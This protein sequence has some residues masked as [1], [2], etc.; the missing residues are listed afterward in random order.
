MSEE[1][2]NPVY[3]T[4]I[5]FTVK[6]GTEH[7]R[8]PSTIDDN[9]K[10]PTNIATIETNDFDAYYYFPSGELIYTRDTGR[11][12]IGNNTYPA[13]KAGSISESGISN[14]ITPGGVLA[15]NKYLG[16]FSDLAF[17]NKHFKFSEYNSNTDAY[18]GD[19]R[20]DANSSILY[21]YDTNVVAPKLTTTALSNIHN[22]S[23]ISG[24]LNGLK[25]GTSSKKEDN[26]K[27]IPFFNFIPDGRT[28]D[29]DNNSEVN[30][31]YTVTGDEN[32]TSEDSTSE[33]VSYKFKILKVVNIESEPVH[34]WFDHSKNHNTKD[35]KVTTDFFVDTKDN[36]KLK[37]RLNETILKDVYQRTAVKE[38]EKHRVVITDATGDL[39]IYSYISKL[40]LDKL[41]GL[42][43]Y[44]RY[45]LNNNDSMS[46]IALQHHIGQPFYMG[47][48]TTKINGGKYN[49]ET[50]RT[51]YIKGN[52]I[53]RDKNMYSKWNTAYSSLWSNIGAPEWIDGTNRGSIWN[54]IGNSTNYVGD[55]E[56]DGKNSAANQ[57]PTSGLAHFDHNINSSGKAS[58]NVIDIWYNIGDPLTYANIWK[59]EKGKRTNTKQIRGN[60]VPTTASGYS[61][62][63]RYQSLWESIGERKKSAT[64]AGHYNLW[65]HIGDKTTYT[66][67]LQTI[68][69]PSSPSSNPIPSIGTK[70]DSLSTLKTTVWGG[71][72]NLR[73][74]INALY[75]GL[76]NACTYIKGYVDN[77]ADSLRKYIDS[78]IA[79]LKS[80]LNSVSYHGSP[81]YHKYVDLTAL[82]KDNAPR[83]TG[84]YVTEYD[85]WL[86]IETP[87]NS[88]GSEL[89]VRAVGHADFVSISYITSNY[90]DGSQEGPYL[91]PFMKGDTIKIV[92]RGSWS[93]EGAGTNS[94]IFRYYGKR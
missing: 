44:R 42:A 73:S 9:K 45:D 62:G 41:N 27:F 64:D 23:A 40:E 83:G 39:H 58:G 12:F 38:T 48:A 32:S 17:D 28:L 18:N 43:H 63:Y 29:I 68:S 50:Y 94:H 21:L 82:F 26:R 3:D 59:Y 34:Q 49:E 31:F 66:T 13:I 4:V 70:A 30:R 81:N 56:H 67:K 20:F 87:Y 51:T 65:N 79:K 77:K 72:E 69:W 91:L 47:S 57:A 22:T 25:E 60:V 2:T 75:G 54:N 78:E 88:G 92:P 11:L 14:Q 89:Q 53:A 24:L 85:G 1:A 35:N 76:K 71:I 10:R 15:G 86:Y 93:W 90:G 52:H 74:Q 7:E 36:N 16:S 55:G 6:Q 61:S 5:R 84:T 80:Y 46:Y 19:Y 37:L 8:C 33:D